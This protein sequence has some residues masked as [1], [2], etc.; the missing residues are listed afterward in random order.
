[1]KSKSEIMPI[2]YLFSRQGSI[3]FEIDLKQR[4]EIIEQIFREKKVVKTFLGMNTS[5]GVFLLIKRR[6]A[7]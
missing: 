5:F 3:Y 6:V 1:M 4:F 7:S 2:L